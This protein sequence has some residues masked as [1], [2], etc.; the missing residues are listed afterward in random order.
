MASEPRA[1]V[2]VRD[3]G[4]DKD[5][6]VLQQELWLFGSKLRFT[7]L[8]PERGRTLRDAVDP[9]AKEEI[10]ADD[11][12]ETAAIDRPLANVGR[13]STAAGSLPSK[14]EGAVRPVFRPKGA[15]A[16]ARTFRACFPACSRDL[17]SAGHDSIRQRHA[18]LRL[19]TG[20][21]R[22][23]PGNPQRRIVR[24]VGSQRRRQ[25]HNHQN[26][27]RVAAAQFGHRSASAVTT[28]F[29]TTSGPAGCWV[30]CPTS[31]ICTTS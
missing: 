15:D 29:A 5:G 13:W 17:V 22:P 3:D 26:A 19:E 2:W 20:R 7:R 25:N 11:E 31:P 24:P 4:H 28:W 16:A 23:E 9:Y 12:Q 14:T 8:T 10:P 30:T 27:R 1:K 6:L 21:F 18:C